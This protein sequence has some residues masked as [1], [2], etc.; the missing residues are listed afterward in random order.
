MP[1]P[2][3]THCG[4]Q[5]SER[6]EFVS[7]TTISQAGRVSVRSI[8]RDSYSSV[9]PLK[10][11]SQKVFFWGERKKKR[12]FF[13][14]YMQMK[15]ITLIICMTKPSLKNVGKAFIN[16]LILKTKSSNHKLSCFKILFQQHS[17]QSV[18]HNEVGTS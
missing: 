9:R 7:D 3:S 12:I 17:D 2:S 1:K 5:V 13:N 8:Q 15:N 11:V 10:N 16:S 14:L 6:L 4:L 18:T